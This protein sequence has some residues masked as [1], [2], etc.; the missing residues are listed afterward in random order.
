[1]VKN[2][3]KSTKIKR[4]REDWILDIFITFV[5]GFISICCLYPMVHVFF[6]SISEPIQ[7][8]FHSG[9]LLWPKGFSVAAYEAVIKRKDI[10]IGYGNTLFYVG[11]GTVVN[12]VMTVVGAYALSRKQFMF[13]KAFTLFIVFSMYF[14]ASIIPNYLLMKGLHLLNTRWAL[15]LPGAIGTHNL[16][17]LRTAFRKVPESLEEASIL[18]GANDFQVLFHVLLPLTK[19]TLA[20]ILLFYVVGHW[21]SWFNA[22]AYLPMARNLYPLQLTLREI[23]IS[24]SEGISSGTVVDYLGESVRYAAI[25]VSTLPILCIYPFVQKHF[26]KGIMLGSVKG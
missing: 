23:I 22:M 7:I 18:D 9:P 21:N 4:T 20:V 13:K 12:M 26:V 16:L 14:S 11:V 24:N 3:I 2:R 1:M 10:W 25:I 17:V 6:A 15:V 19:A 5:V 8:M